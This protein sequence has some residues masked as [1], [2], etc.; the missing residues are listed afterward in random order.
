ML[1]QSYVKISVQS[2]EN[3]N[4]L[5]SNSKSQ[6]IP[7]FWYPIITGALITWVMFSLFW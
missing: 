5:F 2:D 7:R 3:K 1:K 6:K 4:G